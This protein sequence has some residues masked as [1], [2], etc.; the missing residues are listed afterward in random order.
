MKIIIE[1]N[2]KEECYKLCDKDSEIFYSD[3][4]H[5]DIKEIELIANVFE[6]HNAVEI[7]RLLNNKDNRLK[8]DKK[9]K[10]GAD[11]Y[12]GDSI[13][14]KNFI[15]EVCVIDGIFSITSSQS[16]QSLEEIGLDD[17]EV[18]RSLY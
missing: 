11:I 4:S 13:R 2:S 8:Y 6:R 17:I 1:T 12:E 10:N 3:K 5:E 15:D 18:M 7:A 14:G 9:D 16:N